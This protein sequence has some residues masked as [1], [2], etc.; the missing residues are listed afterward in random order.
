MFGT[1][2][3]FA[4]DISGNFVSST[5]CNGRLIY[6]C[7]YI[8]T[9]T[10]YWTVFKVASSNLTP[11]NLVL[12][13]TNVTENMP[14]ATTVGSFSTQDPD[15]GDTFTYVL[16]NGTGGTDNGSFTISGSNLLTAAIFNYEV[17]SNYSICVQSADQGGLSTQAI[18]SINI[19]DIDEPAPSFADA[20]IMSDGNMVI[21]WGSLSNKQYTIH[22]STNLLTGFPL[23]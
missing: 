20:P 15:M 10:N 1:I 14:I 21:R 5:Q 19:L 12:S 9:Y 4:Y 8:T 11:T 2:G 18:F 16:T 3:Y 17:K 22:Y 6:T 13:N 7:D 23:L